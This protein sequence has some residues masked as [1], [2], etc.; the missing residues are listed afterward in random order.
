[1]IA[2]RTQHTLYDEW[3]HRIYMTSVF[4]HLRKND[5]PAFSKKNYHFNIAIISAPFCP[6]TP[7]PPP[8]FKFC[9]INGSTLSARLSLAPLSASR[10]PRM[11]QKAKS[12]ITVDVLWLVMQKYC[13]AEFTK[14]DS[15]LEHLLSVPPNLQGIVHKRKEIARGKVTK[16]LIG[17]ATKWTFKFLRN[18][19]SWEMLH[20]LS[21]IFTNFT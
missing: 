15:V 21:S 5:K 18:T 8:P 10:S 2:S 13:A 17:K 16:L 4:V 14:F 19:N 1:M 3:G 9:M 11:S 20:G 7:P 6:T 12:E